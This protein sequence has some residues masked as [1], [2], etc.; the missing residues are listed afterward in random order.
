[1]WKKYI[2]NNSLLQNSPKIC[3]Y[4]RISTLIPHVS[5]KDHKSG[6]QWN[7]QMYHPRLVQHIIW[8]DRILKFRKGLEIKPDNK[9][10]L[11]RNLLPRISATVYFATAPNSQLPL[12]KI[13]SPLLKFTTQNVILHRYRYYFHSFFDPKNRKILMKFWGKVKKPIATKRNIAIW[14]LD[15]ISIFF[16]KN[17]FNSKYKKYIYKNKFTGFSFIYSMQIRSTGNRTN[18]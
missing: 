7:W 17:I 13:R 14:I 4:R 10:K 12:W 6:I 1:M 18:K 2:K 3:I 11:I 15:A 16:S 9:L 5:L 8:K